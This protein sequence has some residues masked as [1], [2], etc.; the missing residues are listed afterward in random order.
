MID[1]KEI[2]K[3]IEALHSLM[4]H[5]GW[6]TFSETI[7]LLQGRYTA[8]LFKKT[9]MN[10]KP[11]EKDMEHRKIVEINVVLN[12]IL[13]LPQWLEKRKPSRYLD[14]LDHMNK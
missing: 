5:W 14:V 8:E 13:E 4:G 10:L 7:M 11:I 1:E 2:D 6:K 3:K 9:F 12:R